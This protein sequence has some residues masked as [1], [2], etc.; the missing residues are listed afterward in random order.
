MLGGLFDFL[1]QGGTGSTVVGFV[2][3]IQ[4]VYEQQ[5]VALTAEML[6]TYRNQGGLDLL[7]RRCIQRAKGWGGDA[8]MYRSIPDY[9]VQTTKFNPKNS[10]ENFPET[11]EGMEKFKAACQA[12]KLDGLVLL[13]GCRTAT[14]EK[15]GRW[16]GRRR[17]GGGGG[18]G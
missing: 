4:G 6:A 14:G 17:E 3:G 7:G 16:M 15:S 12:L 8:L 10:H 9:T 2:G 13:G 5:T 18:D 1:T 11:A